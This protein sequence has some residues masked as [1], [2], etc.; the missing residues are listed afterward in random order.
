[1]NDTDRAVQPEAPTLQEQIEWATSE[2]NTAVANGLIG[3]ARIIGRRLD[4]L[5]ARA[6][7]Q[8][9]PRSLNDIRRAA[10][11]PQER[12]NMD[13]ETPDEVTASQEA[14]TCQRKDALGSYVP[15]SLHDV[16]VAQ[17]RPHPC[18]DC[19]EDAFTGSGRGICA[20]HEAAAQER[21]PIDVLREALQ[22]SAERF[23]GL[24]DDPPHLYHIFRECPH[25][26]CV[27]A[28]TALA[29]GSVASPDQEEPS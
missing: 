22:Q 24:T 12:Y 8:E 9:R 23:H 6:A 4:A 18:T 29:G 14:C 17:E 27:E 7:S 5:E 20:Y 13:F 1:M 10:S 25:V 15:C 2:Y 19:A 21:P 28:R 26:Y 16:G 11:E 3:R